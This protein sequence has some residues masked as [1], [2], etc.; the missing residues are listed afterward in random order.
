MEGIGTLLERYKQITVPIYQRNYSWNVDQVKELLDDL[1]GSMQSGRPHFL[2]CLILQDEKNDE[3]KCEV[4]DGQQRITTVFLT[5]ARIQDELHRLSRSGF[6][7]IHGEGDELERN[8]KIDVQQ[9]IFDELLSR[10]RFVSNPLISDMFRDKMLNPKRQE[11][12]PERDAVQ[13]AITLPLRKAYWEVRDRVQ[14]LI[15][16]DQNSESVQLELLAKLLEAVKRL[17]VLCITTSKQEES[18]EVFLT[19]NNR[20]LPLG[21]SD[22]IRGQLIQ[23]LTEGL[24]EA[25]VREVH[26][27]VVREWQ[28]IMTSFDDAG[29]QQNSIDQFF[30]Y[31]LLATGKSKVG[32]RHAPKEMEKRIRQTLVADKLVD[33]SLEERRTEAERIWKEVQT[34]ARTWITVLDPSNDLSD[35][36]IYQLQI[37]RHISDNYRVLLLNVF[38]PVVSISSHDKTEIAR[39]CVV[40]TLRWYLNGQGAQ[41]LESTFQALGATF[42]S[43]H[44]AKS[45][46]EQLRDKAQI[47]PPLEARF[48]EGENRN[49]KAILHGIERSLALKVGANPISWSTTSLHVE[50]VAPDSSTTTWVEILFPEGDDQNKYEETVSQLGNLTILDRKLNLKAQQSPFELKKDKYKSSTSIMTRDLCAL[51]D[52]DSEQISS[53]Q[54]WLAEMFDVVWSTDLPDL[55]SKLHQYSSWRNLKK[56]TS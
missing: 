36:C 52:W 40:L 22:I 53:R 49:A 42:A 9:M 26:N 50:H 4:V 19:L 24:T 34:Y 27:K 35:D 48:R 47:S 45:L 55:E 17:Q 18:L 44:D 6:Q 7:T 28:A 5:L 14:A 30:R 20:G 29:E 11:E 13:K 25:R 8:P 12:P 38:N 21:P 15:R 41:D 43:T 37:L 33:R 1:I 10:P 54:R 31:Y 39:L 3:S 56:S 51:E 32:A 46:I 2:G 23:A 16:P